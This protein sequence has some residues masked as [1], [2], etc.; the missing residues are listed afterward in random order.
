MLRIVKNKVNSKRL[1]INEEKTVSLP[2]TVF[3][4]FTVVILN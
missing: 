1:G 3:E 2:N 4:E